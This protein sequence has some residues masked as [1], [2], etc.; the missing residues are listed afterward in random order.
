MKKIK[1]LLVL[2]VVMCLLSACGSSASSLVG[3]WEAVDY[4]SDIW[5]SSFPGEIRI[6]NDGDISLDSVAGTYTIDG[7]T[8]NITA[9][10][11]ALSYDFSVSGDTLTL[12]NNK[13]SVEYKKV[14]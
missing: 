8:I 6:M 11:E 10:W 1:S 3:E 2:L 14:Q 5:V 12:S 9:S 7:N 4:S 13:K